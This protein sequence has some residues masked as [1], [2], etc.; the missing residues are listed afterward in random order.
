MRAASAVYAEFGA[1]SG[2]RKWKDI[3]NALGKREKPEFRLLFFSPLQKTL[4]KHK[5]CGET[6]SPHSAGDPLMSTSLLSGTDSRVIFL[7]LPCDP[8]LLSEIN[9]MLR[10][11]EVLQEE[12]P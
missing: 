2:G 12:S 5:G 4:P 10:P 7:L 6:L 11:G 9:R 8:C 3:R 1:S